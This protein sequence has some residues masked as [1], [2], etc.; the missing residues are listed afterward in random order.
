MNCW[1]NWFGAILK[2]SR[3]NILLAIIVVF[4][5]FS[6]AYASQHEHRKAVIV[7][8]NF[9]NLEEFISMQNVKKLMEHGAVGLMNT[10]G[11][12]KT[13]SIRAFATLGWGTRADAVP[14]H[15]LVERKGTFLYVKNID[16]II[17]SNDSNT[18]NVSVGSLGDFFHQKGLKTA[19]IGNQDNN[20]IQ[21]SPAALI[22]MDSR[23][24]IDDGEIGE[25]IMLPGN[26]LPGYATDYQLLYEVFRKKYSVND[27][28]VVD[29][30]DTS[31]LEYYHN[32][33]MAL[34]ADKNKILKDIDVFLG[35]LAAA[36]DRDNT[37]LILLSPHYSSGDARFG[38]KLSPV[39]LYGKDISKG[40]LISDT[41][42]RAGIIG[43]IDIAPTI[44]AFFGGTLDQAVGEAVKVKTTANHLTK[45]L[46]LYYLTAFNAKN[47]AII[48]KTYVSFQIVLLILTL[49]FILLK[50]KTSKKFGIVLRT[51]ILFTLTCPLTLFLM[52]L[53][54][55]YN[56][57]VFSL[58][59][60]GI[61]GILAYTIHIISENVE[62][63]IIYISWCTLIL[64]L[65]DLVFKGPLNRTS[66]LGYDA[67]IG[68]RYYGLG[69]EYMGV[70]IATTLIGVIPLVYKKVFPK[71][72]AV[73]VFVLITPVIGLSMFGANVGGTITASIAF[74]FAILNIYDKKIT[75]KKII[76]LFIVMTLI[77]SAFAA[78]DIYFA[79]HKSH[80]A[81]AI[82]EFRSGGIGTV[83]DII[84]RKLEMNLKLLRWTIW[85]EVLL[86][87]VI[88][89]AVLFLKPRGALHRLFNKYKS[90]SIAWYS[91]LVA[92]ITGMLVND[93]GVVVAATSNIF[94]IFSLLYFLLGEEEGGIQRIREDRA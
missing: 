94:L 37:L 35:K 68:A 65:A 53:L 91:I 89:M 77:V 70:F 33:G 21:Y 52:P 24:M 86:V 75:V 42:R 59:L 69:N 63:N 27:F 11:G 30:G 15:C 12:S 34:Y 88:V 81:K 57:F 49:I 40:L 47:R 51:L 22:A 38:R 67:V 17:A 56:L 26:E 90:F 29:T 6:T 62:T 93:S 5:S 36:V 4:C 87:S 80:L 60:I 16:D 20:D 64:I 8:I 41:T 54:R 13:D 66:L 14:N 76:S 39:V 23:G 31:R 25:N 10:R 74:G 19:L 92:S 61:N 9:T 50:N 2:K 45:A 73:A 78:Y 55:V 48:L 3:H 46:S 44:A 7:T 71:W 43:N 28:I 72:V 84:R 85:S 82:L 32:N 18:Y 83:L 58:L 1:R 79:Q